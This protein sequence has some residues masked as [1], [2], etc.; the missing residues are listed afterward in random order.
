MSV[1]GIGQNYLQKLVELV[2]SVLD[3]RGDWPNLLQE[4]MG[5]IKFS[6]RVDGLGQGCM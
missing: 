1:G 2:K 3:S 6:E 4:R 5:L